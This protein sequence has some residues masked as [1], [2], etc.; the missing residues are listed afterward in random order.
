MIS[1][2]LRVVCCAVLLLPVLAL[3][4]EGTTVIKGKVID[5]AGNPLPGA[6]VIVELTNLGAAS[7][8]DGEYSFTVPAKAVKGQEV[9]LTAR[10]IGYRS[11]TEKIVLRAGTVEKDFRLAHDVLNLDA[12][13]VTGVVDVTPREKLA[14]SV[15]TVNQQL[16]ELVPASSPEIALQGKIPGVRVIKGSGEPGNSASVELRAPTSINASGRSQDPLYIVDGVIIDPSISG[17]PLADINAD[18]IETM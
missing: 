5:P 7:G 14:F 13:V 16:L 17:S 9:R 2:T 4:Q 18:E 3:A 15:G 10:F 12:I 1:K 11:S 8:P 6:N